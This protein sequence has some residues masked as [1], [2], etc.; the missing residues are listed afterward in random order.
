LDVPSVQ[1]PEFP[2]IARAL[3]LLSDGEALDAE[4]RWC[5]AERR[6]PP[7]IG[8]LPAALSDALAAARAQAARECLERADAALWAAAGRCSRGWELNVGW[9]RIERELTDRERELVAVSGRRGRKLQT[10]WRD[11]KARARSAVKPPADLDSLNAVAK[12]SAG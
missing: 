6:S 4:A 9:Q 3:A 5:L 7:R 12:A 10:A 1:C 11:A 2:A 8:P